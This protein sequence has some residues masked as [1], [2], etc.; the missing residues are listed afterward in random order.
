MYRITAVLNPLLESAAVY[1]LYTGLLELADE[2]K[3]Q[4]AWRTKGTWEDFAI[5]MEIERVADGATRRICFDI[6]DRSY[7]FSERLLAE[8]DVYFKRDHYGPDV[9]KLPAEARRKV[10]PFG[11]IFGPGSRAAPL[12]MLAGWARYAA[13]RPKRAWRTF[14]QLTD[15]LRLP[16]TGEF[17]RGPEHEMPPRVLLQTRLWTEDEITGAPF[18]PEI[19]ADRVG[20]VRA[21]RKTL[22][23]RFV[24]GALPTPFA[25]REFPDVVCH[26]DTRRS[27]YLGTMKGCLVGIYTMGLH[28]AT[29]WKLGEYLAASMCIVASGLRNDFEEPFTDPRNYL[30]FTT[31]DECAEKCVR[32]LENRDE[33]RAMVRANHAYY[34]AQVRPAK[35]LL[36]WIG[37][38]FAT[39]KT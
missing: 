17:E 4:L 39:A 8:C 18:A 3:I 11:P 12:G 10:R 16:Q 9:A 7:L 2:G 36:H 20:L 26:W 13:V 37:L 15:Y 19:N 21:L 6:H 33:A 22:G 28:Y 35:Q 27:A 1:Y 38:A 25:L 23:D 29:A 34:C 5:F 32:L 31:P 14:R 24:G 30:G